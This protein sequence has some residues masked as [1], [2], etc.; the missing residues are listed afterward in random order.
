MSILFNR[1]YVAQSP[2][3]SRFCVI[4]CSRITAGYGF[5]TTSPLA[6]GQMLLVQR[7]PG[8]N[9]ANS[10]RSALGQIAFYYD[11]ADSPSNS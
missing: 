5:E 6:I 9:V 2:T 7:G 8:L 10:S 11:I 3:G 1:K 4:L